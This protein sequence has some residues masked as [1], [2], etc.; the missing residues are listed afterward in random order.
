MLSFPQAISFVFFF[1]TTISC[2]LR[3]VIIDDPSSRLLFFFALSSSWLHMVSTLHT[4]HFPSGEYTKTIT[5]N[6][7]PTQL[8]NYQISTE[9]CAPSWNVVYDLISSWK[10]L[11]LELF[12]LSAALLSLSVGPFSVLWWWM[13]FFPLCSSMSVS[14]LRSSLL[15]WWHPFSSSGFWPVFLFY[16]I[17]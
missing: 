9:N 12:L 3:C 11:W 4:L 14:L 17:F 1:C 7:V 2:F 5:V 6:K 16:F 15:W 13:G 8:T 10:L